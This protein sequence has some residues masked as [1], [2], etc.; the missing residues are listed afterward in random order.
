[1]GGGLY[2]QWLFR[3]C[4]RVM[5]KKKHTLAVAR[6]DFETASY[7]GG[8][9]KIFF[10]TLSLKMGGD[11]SKVFTNSPCGTVLSQERFIF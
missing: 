3:S 11:L 6:E 10:T 2:T 9:M 5:Q 7:H 4:A 1:M 8:E